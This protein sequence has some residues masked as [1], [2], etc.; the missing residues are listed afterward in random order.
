MMNSSNSFW[1]NFMTPPTYLHPTYL[2]SSSQN[3]Y[4]DW[5]H[6]HHS[7]YRSPYSTTSN[8]SSNHLHPI[9]SPN[10]TN[11]NPARYHHHSP[12]DMDVATAAAIG[13]VAAAQ[14]FHHEKQS[15]HTYTPT[16]HHFDYHLGGSMMASTSNPFPAQSKTYHLK[17]VVFLQ[18]SLSIAF[19]LMNSV[20]E[21][22]NN[23]DLTASSAWYSNH[24]LF[25]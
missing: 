4:S 19:D 6:Q 14:M 18:N 21:N 16:S 24:H 13:A 8:F 11:T 3:D 17:K 23:K 20:T 9:G 12:S 5:M 7:S 25:C 1:P 15:H 22:P 2:S 10:Q